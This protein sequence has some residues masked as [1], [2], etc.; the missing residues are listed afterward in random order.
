MFDRNLAP[1]RVLLAEPL[2]YQ[3]LIHHRHLARSGDLALF[4]QA[5]VQQPGSQGVHVAFADQLIDGLPAVAVRLAGD[6]QVCRDAA[7]RRQGAGFGGIHHSG[8]RLQLGQQLAEETLLFGRGLIL[9]LGKWQPR[10]QNVVRIESQVHRLQRDKG[11]HHDSGAGQQHQRE[12]EFDDHQ[13]IPQPSAPEAAA[14]AAAGILQRLDNIA[15]RQLQRRRKPEEQ[16]GEDG[17]AAG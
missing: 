10:H 3:S 9:P 11:P 14:D 12:R 5:A 7:V 4:H 2:R 13:R 8:E 6:V 1:D 15:A 16:R 17:E